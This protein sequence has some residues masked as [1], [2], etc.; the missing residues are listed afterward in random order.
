MENAQK[1]YQNEQFQELNEHAE[2]DIGLFYR[3]I[4]EQR[5]RET[6]ASELR[7]DGEVTR[8]TDRIL[9]AWTDHYSTLAKPT[10]KPHFDETFKSS[11][12]NDLKRIHYKP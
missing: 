2:I 5:R 6:R 10:M 9:K 11:V 7:V 12:G 8:D 1:Q 3:T 4:R